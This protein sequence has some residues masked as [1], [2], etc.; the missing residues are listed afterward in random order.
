MIPPPAAYAATL[1]WMCVP[2]MLWCVLASLELIAVR[3]AFRPGAPLG[4]DLAALT[5]GR[6]RPAILSSSACGP[7]ALLVVPALRLAAG[8]ALPF[9]GDATLVVLLLVILCGTALSNLATQGG[10]GADKIAM[11]ACSAAL[12]IALGRLLDDSLLCLAGLVWGAGQVTIAYVAS[13]AAKLARGFW[14]DGSAIAAAM[15]SYRSGH[16][17]TARIV[18]HAPAARALAWTIMLVE[19]LFPLALVA[20]PTACI[21]LLAAMA[22]FHLATAIVMGLNTYPWAFMATY[23]CIVMANAILAA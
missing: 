12:L 15:T 21:A 9:A 14:R 6:L 20:G 23:P 17:V 1:S 16:A 4:T 18:R 10:D 5:R 19:T 22:L 7:A 11:V 13:G 3:W 2:L 8:L